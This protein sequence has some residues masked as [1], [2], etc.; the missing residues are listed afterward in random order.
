MDVRE[1]PRMGRHLRLPTGSFLVLNCPSRTK[2]CG[3]SG[4]GKETA[5]VRGPTSELLFRASVSGDARRHR[6]VLAAVFENA[7]LEAHRSGERHPCS[8]QLQAT[9]GHRH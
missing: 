1:A 3:H 9:T 8:L 4:G 2:R 5:E 6:G 7:G